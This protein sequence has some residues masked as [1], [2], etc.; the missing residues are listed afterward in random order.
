MDKNKGRNIFKYLKDKYGKEVVRLLR[1]WEN[2]SERM[3]DF[4]NHRWFTLRC[5]K[6]RITPVSSKLKTLQ[7]K[8]AKSFH[9]FHEAERQLLYDRVRSINILLNKL[10]KYW[11]WMFLILFD[12]MY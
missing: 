6:V 5:T 8:T 10:E 1:N 12:I 9:I 7:F 11:L 4:R 2:I 3:V